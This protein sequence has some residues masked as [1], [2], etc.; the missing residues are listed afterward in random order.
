MPSLLPLAVFS[1]CLFMAQASN[2]QSPQRSYQPSELRSDLDR[3][4]RALRSKHP[5]LFM[6]ASPERLEHAFDSLHAAIR[7]PLTELE[8]LSVIASLYPLLGD[9]H[10]LFLPSRADASRKKRHLPF[11]LHWIDGHLWVIGN[12]SSDNRLA[13]GTEITSINGIPSAAIVD[14]LMMRQVRDGRNTT[15]PSWILNHYFKEYYRFSFGEPDSFSMGSSASGGIERTVVRSLPSDS[16]EDNIARRLLA[17]GMQQAY[18]FGIRYE[19]DGTAVLRIPSFERGSFSRT[20]LDDSF[21]E[22]RAKQARRLILDLRGNQGG[23]PRLA[24]RLLAHL[25]GEPFELVREGPASGMT[26]PRPVIFEGEVAALMDGGSFSVTGMVLACLERHGRAV[27]IGEEAGGNRTVLAGSP[28]RV[29]LPHTRIECH[30]ST[31]LWLLADRPNDGHG[32]MPTLAVRPT[33]DDLLNGKD[34]V[35]QAALNRLGSR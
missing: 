9:G 23:E 16:I 18:G 32:V 12:G 4:E 17:N 21:E 1:L 35:M 24:K 11:L 31:R 8:F 2:G 30:I 7:H 3:L 22:L 34:R 5:A 10:T 19:S 14:T 20:E 13:A 26:R 28:K 25:L 15:Y 29:V 6:Y 27:F 33:T